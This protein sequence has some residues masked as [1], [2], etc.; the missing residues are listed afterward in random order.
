MWKRKIGMYIDLFYFIFHSAN[1]TKRNDG[2][3]NRAQ[4]ESRHR[5]E[6]ARVQW[7]TTF[8]IRKNLFI[9]FVLSFIAPD[10]K[11]YVLSLFFRCLCP[12][13]VRASERMC[14]WVRMHANV[15]VLFML[16]RP[17]IYIFF[18]YSLI[19]STLRSVDVSAESKQF[20]EL[21][22]ER[23]KALAAQ[24]EALK[25]ASSDGKC[26]S[27]F[28]KQ[29]WECGICC[30]I[31]SFL[32]HCTYIFLSCY[33]ICSSQFDMT[34]SFR[35]SLTYYLIS[36][37]NWIS[38]C[39]STGPPSAPDTC[40]YFIEKPRYIYRKVN[41]FPVLAWHNCPCPQNTFGSNNPFM[42]L[43]QDLLF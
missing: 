22:L 21:L 11:R 38:E 10:R 25:S 31:N 20:Q 7:K 29:L 3:T 42:V 8:W 35:F 14:G 12:W 4:D 30:K 19:T 32:S 41:A 23:T 17:L 43:L 5:W 39:I 33:L 1:N 9:L 37:R 27:W 26:W 2:F 15:F 28:R 24:T 18:I 6:P 16:Q 13:S 40:T 34:W 36:N